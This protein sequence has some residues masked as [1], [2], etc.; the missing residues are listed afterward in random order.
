MLTTLRTIQQ[1]LHATGERGQI[2]IMVG[3]TAVLLFAVTGLAVDVG[4]MYIL[5]ARLSRAM[6]AAAL[7]G[8]LELPDVTAATAA[9]EAYLA[10]N[11]GNVIAK[12]GATE[13]CTSPG[14]NLLKVEGRKSVEFFFIRVLGITDKNVSAKASAGFGVVSLDAALV[15]DATSSMG[16]SPCDGEQDNTGCPIWEAKNAAKDFKDILLGSSPG[17]ETAVGVAAFRGC[18]KAPTQTATAPMPTSKGNC[19]LHDTSASTQVTQLIYNVATLNTQINN[20]SAI[21]G[22]G[23]NVCGGLSKGWEVLEGPGNHLSESNNLRYLILLSD[24][25][26]RY[27]GSYTYQSSPYDSPH[28]YQSM[29]CRPPQ[30]CSN[31]GGDSTG[32]NPCVSAVYTPITTIVSDNFDGPSSSCPSAWNAGSGWTSDWTRNPTSGNDAATYLSTSSPNDTSCHVR[33]RGIGYMYR[34]FSLSGY[35]TAT[36]RYYAKYNS[37]G[38]GD[39]AMV[40][41]STDGTSWTTLRTHTTSNT[42]T[43][44]N[45]FSNSLDAYAGQATV[46]L[47]F[48]GS[49]TPNDAGDYFFIDTITV[50]TGSSGSSDGYLNGDDNS[51]NCSSP[52]KRERQL[53]ILTWNVAKAIEADDVEIYVVA[54]GVCSSN[55]TTYTQAQCDSQV[56]N[57]DT[58]STG[59]QRLLKCIA[60]SKPST[61]DHYFYASSAGALPA[62]FSQIAKQI[63]HRLIE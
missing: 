39:D 63:A 33:I 10:A 54:F 25:D 35:T 50:Q 51:G 34:T 56:G 4:R 8:V 17:G 62:I 20:I 31:V 15:I 38:S 6:D 43:G 28:T 14:E 60:S 47:R 36:L 16:D 42:G 7:A 11:E 5:K 49:M 58:D 27:T 26:N 29:P 57:T 22:S 44:Y 46:Y 32:S 45:S 40:E 24:G 19:V 21:G 55:S 37:W 53:D 48:T 9:C 23:T 2:L 12:Q 1:R 52:V 30:S 41:I 13:I 18:Y 61:N 59:D 3:L